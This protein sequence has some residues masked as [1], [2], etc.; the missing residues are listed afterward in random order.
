MLAKLGARLFGD[1][2]QSIRVVSGELDTARLPGN[3]IIVGRSLLESVDGTEPVAGFLLR[4][5][6]RAEASDP[7]AEFFRAAGAA[8]ATALALGRAA[9]EDEFRQAALAYVQADEPEVTA[10]SLIQ[11]FRSAGIPSTPFARSLGRSDPLAYELA[12][13]D[14]FRSASYAPLL[15]DADWLTLQALCEYSSSGDLAVN[16]PH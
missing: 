11:A 12:R 10:E 13:Q 1:N 16:E 7:L 14:P 8:A 5:R 4:E 15:D 3:V 9:D 2:S 6:L